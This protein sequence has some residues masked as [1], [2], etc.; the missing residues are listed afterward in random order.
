MDDEDLRLTIY[1]SFAT[2]GSAPTQAALAA[3]IGADVDTVRDGLHRLAAARHLVLD[4][5][6]AIVMAHPFTSINLGFSV[7]GRST[8]WWGG[9]AWDAFAIPQLVRDEPERPR[10][11]ALPRMRHPARMGGGPLGSAVGQPGGALPRARG[12]HVG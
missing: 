2:M 6:D 10:R 1:Q 8:L 4:D 11:H 5:T 12:P 3:A 9:C 7:M